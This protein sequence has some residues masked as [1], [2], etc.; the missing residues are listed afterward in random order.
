MR[1]LSAE[2]TGLKCNFNNNI[3][4]VPAG[5]TDYDGPALPAMASPVAPAP[6]ALP[7]NP[8]VPTAPPKPVNSSDL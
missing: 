8:G 3:V 1:F 2:P 6:P 5:S 7:G 4:L